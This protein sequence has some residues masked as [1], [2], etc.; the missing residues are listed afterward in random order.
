MTIF[1]IA[2]LPTASFKDVEFAYQE[3]SLDGGRKT[4]TH[5]YPN[6]KERY[7]EDLGG[8]EKRF[9]ISAFVDNNVSFGDR[10]ELIDVLESE[11]IGT[12]IHPSYGLQNVICVGYNVV[13]S[14]KEIGISKFTISFEVASLNIAP[15]KLKGNKGFLFN[16]KSKILG[17]NESAFN[18]GWKSVVKAKSKFDSAVKTTKQVAIKIN[19]VSQLVQGSSSSIGDATTSLNQIVAS[20]NSLVQSPSV[21]SANLRTAFDNLSVG[22]NSSRDVFTVMSNLFGFNERD[23]VSN[24]NSSL[25]KDI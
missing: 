1:N 20:A 15:F 8:I 18:S 11:G 23:R 10:D 6:R 13:D 2:R 5:E 21:L 14:I 7:V 12:L 3:S 24:G 9:S 17:D 22:Y 16:L 4:V 19:R 25:Q